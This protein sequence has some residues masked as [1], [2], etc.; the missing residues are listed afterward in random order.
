MPSIPEKTPAHETVYR[1]I[2]DRILYGDLAPG[3]AV[4]I[5]GLAS[6]TG[7][8]MTPVREAIRRLSAE[9]ALEFQGNRRVLVPRMT[10]DRL[11]E[12]AFARLAV[13][14]ELSEMAAKIAPP[15]APAQL[16]GIDNSLNDAIANGDAKAYMRTNHAF[17][18]TLYGWAGSTILLPL[19]E[20][21][22]LRFGPLYRIISGRY[23]TQNLID[24][25][26]EAI[27]ALTRRDSAG[28]AAAIRGD[29]EQGL[30]IVRG[31]L[32]AGEI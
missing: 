18:F 2:R 32:D 24:R 17:H 15:D 10:P 6:E 31:A 23:G 20:S 12:L 5:H 7:A 16:I 25:H 30:E 22:W 4:T 28:V 13:E 27:H 29:I 21:L 8:S 11:A 3:Q 19:A 1:H 26:E 9:G 14:P